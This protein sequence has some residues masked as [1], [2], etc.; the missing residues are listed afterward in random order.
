MSTRDVSD[1][2][3]VWKAANQRIAGNELTTYEN[4]VARKAYRDGWRRGYQEA[5]SRLDDRFRKEMGE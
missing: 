3:A 4:Y 1:D 2:W 5:W